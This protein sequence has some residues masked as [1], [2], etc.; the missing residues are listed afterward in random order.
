M[1]RL[2]SLLVIL[3][4][5]GLVLGLRTSQKREASLKRISSC[6]EM[7]RAWASEE[8]AE[9]SAKGETKEE[10]GHGE[11]HGGPPFMYFVQWL[12]LITTFALGVMY[13]RKVKTQGKPRHEGIKLAYALTVLVLLYFGLGYYPTVKGYHE[14]GLASLL[15]FLV[16]LI[17]GALVTFYGVLGRH[18]E[19]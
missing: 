8:A 3:L 13:A 19:H 2:L 6:L 16:L 7:Q 14:P 10:G 11:G 18:E 5:V 12:I 17:T 9:E 1:R 4:L 15:K